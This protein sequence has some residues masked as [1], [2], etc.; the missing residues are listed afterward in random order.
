MGRELRELL[1]CIDLRVMK[2]EDLAKHIIRTIKDYNAREA[3]SEKLRSIMY[4]DPI[5]TARDQLELM[6]THA[7]IGQIKAKAV[8]DLSDVGHDSNR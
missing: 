1:N 5:E 8:R 7:E 4:N 3:P 2:D 6:K